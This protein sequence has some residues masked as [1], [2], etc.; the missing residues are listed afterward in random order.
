VWTALAHAVN[1][2]STVYAESAATR[3]LVGFAHVGGL[4]VGGGYALAQDHRILTDRRSIW[5]GDVARPAAHG[6]VLVGLGLIM[7][8]GALLLAANTD[9]YGRSAFFWIKMG[10]VAALLANGWVL[11]R[12]E[13][14]ARRRSAVPARL[15][16]AAAVSTM[17]WL[18][19]TLAG[20]VLP[21]V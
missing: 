6:I 12:A 21:N 18:L 8:S 4:L 10:L 3:T 13:A 7:A 11:K 17:L 5:P 20:S 16:R 9:T 2:W 19:T 15:R 1:V 14:D